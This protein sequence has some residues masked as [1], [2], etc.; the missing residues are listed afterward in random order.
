MMVPLT[1]VIETAVPGLIHQTTMAEHLL[2]PRLNGM[3]FLVYK[4]HQCLLQNC[5]LWSPLV[6]FLITNTYFQATL[7][8]YVQ[9]LW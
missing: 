5:L 4:C 3:F 8:L 2:N 1:T 6:I 9:L 7:I